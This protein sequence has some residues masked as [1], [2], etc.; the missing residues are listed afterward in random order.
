MAEW[1][2]GAGTILNVNLSTGKITTEPISK[3]TAAKYIGGRGLA[4]RILYD[5][6]GPGTDPL[7]PG[8]I[9]V[10]ASGSLEG[11]RVPTSG[12]YDL[13]SKCPRTGIYGA[14]N[15]G[16]FFGH[17]MKRAGYDLIVIR[18]ESEKPVYIS[19][20]D[21]DVEIR[22]AGHLWGQD[23]QVTE[24][25]IRD[26]LGDPKIRTLKIG[27]AG[28]NECFSSCV[29]ADLSRAAGRMAFGAVWGS[30][31]LKAVAVRGSKRTNVARPEELKELCRKLRA[32]AKEDPLYELMTV[33]G[34]VGWVWEPGRDPVRHPGTSAENFKSD[35]FDKTAACANCD[36]HC[37]HTYSVKEGKYKGTTGEGPEAGALLN[38]QTIDNPAFMLAHNTL[39]NKLGLDSTFPGIA[40]ERATVLYEKGIITK[41]DTGGIELRPGD[42]ETVLR[43][44]R[45]MARKEGFGK[46][47]DGFPFQT[48]KVRAL[49]KDDGYITDERVAY[50]TRTGFHRGSSASSLA[51]SV[52][53]RGGDHLTGMP[54]ATNRGLLK[55]MTDEVLAK[56]GQDRYGDPEFFF[57]RWGAS[58]KDARRVFD[59]EV[60]CALA[61]MTGTC[62]FRTEWGLSV[63]G[64]HLEDFADLLSA[65]TGVDTTSE[66]LV[67]ATERQNLIQRAFNAREGMRR[68]DDYPYQ[69]RWQL[70]HDMVQ[71]PGWEEL[72]DVTTNS[73]D[74][75][76]HQDIDG[77]GRMLDEYYKLRGCDLETGIPTRERL[78]EL[79]LK[80]V[81]DDLEKRQL[82]SL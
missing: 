77:Y 52:A 28:E 13:T 74:K 35:F 23:T 11:T 51:F 40:I 27:P 57:D 19:I 67:K 4:A 15:G 49:S 54:W 2:G 79:G 3:E 5:E 7:G 53:T 80:D 29:I 30:K 48:V 34:T 45:M 43:L 20:N 42:E 73:H 8:N 76:P 37:S 47:L 21:D 14:S 56:L 32:R 9:I 26:E 66:D 78:E 44:T 65:V 31:R 41:D 25:M 39:C 69:L 38:W 70:E 59:L 50:G 1:Y 71:H 58:S 82:T 75:P 72:G 81:A 68:K 46:V 16:G 36:L 63:A 12:R 64:F 18:G 22:D 61:D 62:K 33:Y 24:E 55:E 10:V 17:E 60:I 6:V